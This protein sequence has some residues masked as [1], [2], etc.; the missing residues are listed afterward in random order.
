[1]YCCCALN[2]WMIAF[3]FPFYSFLFVAVLCANK[4]ALVLCQEKFKYHAFSNFEDAWQHP[5]W[6]KLEDTN[7]EKLFKSFLLSLSDPFSKK[8]CRIT[9]KQ[10]QKGRKTGA[11]THTKHILVLLY[12]LWSGASYLFRWKC[13]TLYWK[14]ALAWMCL[15]WLHN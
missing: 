12:N 9:R 10:Q 14:A 13:I 4:K 6:S 8:L 3:F 11:H 1:M 2:D 5:R 7:F 15:L